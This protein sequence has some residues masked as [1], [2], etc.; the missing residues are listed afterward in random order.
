VVRVAIV[1]SGAAARSHAAAYAAHRGRCA[2]VAVAS[3]RPG[4]AAAFAAEAGIEADPLASHEGLLG[5]RDID[6][7]SVCTPPSEHAMIASE[8]LADGKNVLLEKPMAT[9][10]EDCRRLVGIAASGRA[11]LSPVAQNRFMSQYWRLKALLDSGA[12]GRILF[13]QADSLWWRGDSYY[14]R[15]WRGRWESEGGGCT[16]G[17]AVHHIDL[18]LWMMGM[19]IRATA[20][21]SNVAHP[22]SEMEDISVAALEYPDGAIARLTSSIVHHGEEQSIVLQC[23]K[24]S[25]SAPFRAA[26]RTAGTGG[27]PV[28]DP[29]AAAEL[30]R[31]YEAADPPIFEGLEGQV[32]DV[33]SS[34]E[35]GRRPLVG[36]EDGYNAIQVVAG[37]YASAASGRTVALPLKPGDD[38]YDD[39][40][41][42]IRAPRL[43][44]PRTGQDA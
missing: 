22:S 12:A 25:V 42:V 36:P 31:I 3:P 16:L 39:L 43:H 41:K 8:L 2:V 38:F 23:E 40:S 28:D 1:G 24:A 37:I 32:D 9:S 20:V 11:L 33:L 5:R 14:E 15:P 4:A 34:I 13:A 10:P 26:A 21:M 30:S 7:V 6:L 17:H 29:S 44:P 19:P 35:E 18:L 27:F